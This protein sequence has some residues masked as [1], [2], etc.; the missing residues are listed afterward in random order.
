MTAKTPAKSAKEA[1]QQA[2]TLARERDSYVSGWRA[3]TDAGVVPIRK[4]HLFPVRASENPI[5]R[6]CAVLWPWANR[7]YPGVVRL[8][9][10][11]LG[12]SNL[13]S[14]ATYAKLRVVPASRLRAV[15]SRLRAKASE[16]L[17][18]ADELEHL[19]G[20]GP[21]PDTSKGLSKPQV[22]PPSE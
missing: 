3:R 4:R 17:A 15:A 22:A 11:L 14:V 8:R 6:A 7:E 9:A 13:D 5:V 19:A 1:R 10:W 21:Y 2:E 12:M 20:T 18:M 16:V